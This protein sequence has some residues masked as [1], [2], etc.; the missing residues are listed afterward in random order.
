[1]IDE[2]V[3][4]HTGAW[5]ETSQGK[6]INQILSVAPHTGAWIETSA[7]VLSSGSFSSLPIRER[8]L[9]HRILYHLRDSHA[10]APHTGAWIETNFY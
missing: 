7:G 5:I 9:K 4:P 2:F 8:G 1:M 3:A 10:V 6:D